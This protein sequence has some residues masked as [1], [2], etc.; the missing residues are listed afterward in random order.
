MEYRTLADLEVSAIC[1]GAWM[2][3]AQTPRGEARRIIDMARDAGVNFV[4]TADIYAGGESERIL[5]EALAADRERWV[6]A[7][8]VG[9]PSGAPGRRGLG[10]RWMMQAIDESRRRLDL[11]CIDVYYLH[12]PDPDTPIDESLE[13]LGEIIVQG[14]ARHFGMSNYRG[15]QMADVVHCCR[16]M[17]IAPPLLCQ[18]YYNI[19]NRVAEVEIFPAARHFGI[20]AAV[21]SPLAGGLLT[22]KYRGAEEPDGRGARGDTA[23]SEVEFHDATLGPARRI[24]E[25]AEGRGMSP[26]HFAMR[27][28]V[29]HAD[30]TSAIAGPRT[31]A[32]WAHYLHAL[33]RRLDEDDEAFVSSVVAPGQPSTPGFIGPWDKVPQRDHRPLPS[34]GGPDRGA[35]TKRDA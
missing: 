3:G 2:F 23:F 8:K 31:A 26:T 7:T 13:T 1:L 21:Y 35:G 17:G 15:W 9:A 11:D 5:G 19:L 30:V 20:G 25:Y 24:A 6:V 12:E 27:W 14:K 22:G 16:R 33:D 4:D 34:P 10:R 32:Q 28:V 29:D 18:P